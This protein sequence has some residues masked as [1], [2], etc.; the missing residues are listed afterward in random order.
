MQVLGLV[1]EHLDE[2]DDAAI[3][4]VERAVKLEHPRVALRVLVELRNILRSNQHR[5]VL[6]IRIDRRHYPHAHPIAL[7]EA[8][9]FDGEFFVALAEFLFEA[10][11]AYRAQVAFD[12]HAEHFLELAAQMARNQVQ[13]LLVHR[14]ALDHVDCVDLFEPALNPLDQ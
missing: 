5:G 6:V 4:D 11:A 1:L 13:R 9:R 3:A 7:R 2:L 10:I 12:M 8:A 14:A